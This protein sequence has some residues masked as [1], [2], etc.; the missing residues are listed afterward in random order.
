MGKLMPMG[1]NDDTF[2]KCFKELYEYLWIEIE[3]EYAFWKKKNEKLIIV[4]KKS[5]YNFPK[6]EKFI[7]LKSVHVRAKYRFNHSNGV[8]LSNAE[9]ITLYDQLLDEN[10]IKLEAKRKKL[11]EKLELVQEIEPKYIQ[12][13]INSYFKI[14]HTGQNSIDRKIE[15]IREVSKYKSDKTIDFFQKINAGERNISLRREAFT[16]LQ[17]LNEKVILRRNPKGKKKESQ[18]M[19]YLIEETPDYLIEKIYEDNLEQIKDFD[20]FL[21]HSSNDRKNVVLLYKLLNKNHFHVYIDWVNDKYA[22]K[23]NLLNKNTANVVVQRLNKSKV[24][25]Y[26][27]SEESL[28]SQ[29]TPW[30]VGYFQGIGKQVFVYNP[31][32]LELPTFLQI[33]PAIHIR[34]STIFV[35]DGKNETMFKI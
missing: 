10:K 12:E 35:Y 34:N 14:R 9:Q 32:N 30:E 22:L 28:K 5:R 15:I 8:I 11:F 4:G 2:L 23:R 3:S 1:F 24:L 17:Q 33:Y 18:T 26:F 19:K 29:W 16:V 7:L 20:V 21:S 6:P 31:K 27:H 25:I 13:Y